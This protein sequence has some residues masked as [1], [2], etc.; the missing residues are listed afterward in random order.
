[1]ST[2]NPG[3]PSNTS[4]DP[5]SRAPPNPSAI[6]FDA[7]ASGPPAATAEG[8]KR[9]KKRS[10]K[11]KRARR[12]SFAAPADPMVEGGGASSAQERPGMMDGQDNSAARGS[13][14]RLGNAAR[15]NTS[16]ESEALLDH[17]EQTPMRPRR[18]SLQQGMLTARA[19]QFGRPAWQGQNMGSSTGSLTRSNLAKSQSQSQKYS[20]VDDIDEN[21]PDDRTP[22]IQSSRREKAT[23]PRAAL[24]FGNFFGPSSSSPRETRP[25][26][27]SRGSS[28]SGRPNTGYSNL[29]KSSDNILGYNVN[30]PPSVPG[31]PKLGP[32]MG[33][34]DVLLTGGELNRTR[35]ENNEGEVRRAR[36]AIIDIDEDGQGYSASPV[37][38]GADASHLR[39]HTIAD[40]GAEG[41]VCFPHDDLPSE[42]ETAS[43]G[44]DT[45]RTSRKRGRRWPDLGVL[46]DWTTEEKEQRTMEGIRAR[47]ISE[48]LLVD[49]RLRP[50]KQP[51][52]QTIE[53]APY[54]FTY[55]NEEFQ[56]TIHSQTIS[57]L[58]Q[59]GQS[60]KD[61]F[62][63][64]PPELVDDSSDEEEEPSSTLKV[65]TGQN[66]LRGKV[67]SSIAPQS[68][69]GSV[70]G[71]V[72]KSPRAGETIRQM[73]SGEATGQNTPQRVQTPQKPEKRF[74][75][76]P[77]FWL[78]VMCPTDAEMRVITKAFGIHPL[79]AEDIMMQEAR[80]KVELFRHYYFVNYRT[81]EQD[82]N[83]EDYLEP[84]NMYVVVFR[85]GVISFHFSLTPHPANVRRRI[86]QLTDYLFLTSDW[87]SYAIID[88]ITDVYAPL[89]QRIEEEVD[90][91][92]DAILSLHAMSD[93]D[94][95]AGGML[96]KF[97]NGGRTHS[98]GTNGT[99]AHGDEYDRGSDAGER[100]A[101]KAGDMLR[102]VGECRK[103]V[104]KLYRLLGTKADVIKGFA[105]RC[106]EQWDVA[107]R[108]DIGLYLGDIQDH[109]VTMT[110][111]LSHY[112]SLLSRAHSNYLAQINIRMNERAEK[113]N[114][115]LGKLTVIGTIVLPMNII[116]G[117]WGMNV[118][119]PG[120]DIE[121]LHW[122][123]SI[124]AGLLI[125][126]VG[127]YLIVKK[128][129]GV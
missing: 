73:S 28:R 117:M 34:D 125:F 66:G 50:K 8:G 79:T 27:N 82:T 4:P 18:Q 92:D 81:F 78:D 63:P 9:K 89:I 3:G 21:E 99:T 54:R 30:Y 24:G 45:T 115:I 39:R 42:D 86:R 17:R 111:N 26:R 46:E 32:D 112:E 120:Q 71:S 80:E 122:F 72:Y 118:L 7:E 23:T 103:R 40:F 15:S 95:K 29:R 109:I 121:N 13:L 12:Q 65:N 44:G 67:S 19:S 74:G 113:T 14:Y 68:R 76:R 97:S 6:Q 108:S 107:P 22:L 96:R 98:Y 105:K 94:E 88:D 47:K 90:E 85:E 127:C 55:F 110:G 93:E 84:V 16:L 87:I 69:E 101:E 83:S 64:D 129:Y 37:S 119:V 116:T 56:S 57:E 62:I 70:R 104:M 25:G 2:A 38:P 100:S 58:L 5:N 52:H 60:F 126:G 114:D 35:S 61:L 124:T 128:V 91:I 43:K 41:D 102:R 51:W 59:D 33:Y 48:P 77:T 123:F 10:G 20:D 75:P 53:D 106:N 1:M 49:G 31:S 11:K 36:D